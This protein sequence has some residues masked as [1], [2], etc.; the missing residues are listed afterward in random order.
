M[1]AE[2]LRFNSFYRQVVPHEV[3]GMANYNKNSS[4]YRG[5]EGIN[6]SH[7]IGAAGRRE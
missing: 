5:S 3:V 2:R 1:L 7:Y 4:W 6:K